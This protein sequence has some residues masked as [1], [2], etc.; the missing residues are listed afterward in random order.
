L[1]EVDTNRL[2][3]DNCVQNRVPFQ[4]W[5]LGFYWCC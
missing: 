1:S 2:M 4:L 5:R 3:H